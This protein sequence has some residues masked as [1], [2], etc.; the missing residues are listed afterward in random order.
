MEP[1]YVTNYSPVCFSSIV[2]IIPAA[3][4]LQPLSWRKPK[5]QAVLLWIHFLQKC[6]MAASKGWKVAVLLNP[7]RFFPLPVDEVLQMKCNCGLKTKQGQEISKAWM[8]GRSQ[9]NSRP[10]SS[11]PTMKLCE[12]CSCANKSR[13]DDCPLRC[14]PRCSWWGRAVKCIRFPQYNLRDV[15]PRRL[16]H[17]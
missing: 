15:L 9:R 7:K 3:M 4:I 14:L 1:T 6:T 5:Q 10:N 11:S 8:K 17:A 13:I 16:W 2:T 12:S